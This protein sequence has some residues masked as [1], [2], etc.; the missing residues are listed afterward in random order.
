MI[1]AA[2]AGFVP[3]RHFLLL[4]LILLGANPL[5]G[6]A[7][8][9]ASDEDSPYVAYDPLE[10]LNRKIHSFNT[11][12]DKVALRPLARGYRKVVPSP[13]RRGITNFFSN[14]T[15]PRSSLNNFLQGKPKRGFSELG[16]F[17]FNSTLGLGGFIDIAGAGGLE[18]YDENFAETLSV[19]GV[20]DGPYLVL[21]IWG[22]NM[23]SDVAA[24]PVDYYSDIWTYYDNSSVR[25]KVWALRV[26]DLRYRLLSAD[27][28]LEDSQDPYVAVR[29]AF[30]QNRTFRIYDGD[31]PSNGEQY[32]DELFDEF[33]EEGE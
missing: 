26:I 1:H 23:A 18:R 5:S 9:D 24:L 15:T 12:V 17:I 14:L 20:P 31:P 25:S 13:V 4:M 32:E 28:I 27:S 10:P 3:L 16:R 33:F 6:C 11:V 7:T 19:W 30:R 29:E 21:P 2:R 8:T 22:P